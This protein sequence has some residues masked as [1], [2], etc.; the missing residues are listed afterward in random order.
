MGS[1][2]YNWFSNKFSEY[3]HLNLLECKPRST[4]IGLLASDLFHTGR[5]VKLRQDRFFSCYYQFNFYYSTYHHTLHIM[6]C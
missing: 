1:I 2:S 5:Y 3:Y 4:S 6:S